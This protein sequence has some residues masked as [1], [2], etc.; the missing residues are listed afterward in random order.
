MITSSNSSSAP[1]SVQSS[2]SEPRKPSSG[3]TTPMLAATGSIATTAM[4]LPHSSNAAVTASRSLYGT[5]IVS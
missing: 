5:L 1:C 4:S 2:R 3:A